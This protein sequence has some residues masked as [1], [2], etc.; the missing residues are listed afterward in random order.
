[1]KNMNT[2]TKIVGALS[3]GALALT[4][5]KGGAEADAGEGDAEETTAA[6]GEANSCNGEKA[7]GEG[8]SCGGEGSCGGEDDKK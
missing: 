4:G 5:C 3:L 2:L 6:E 8:N 1:M 7:E